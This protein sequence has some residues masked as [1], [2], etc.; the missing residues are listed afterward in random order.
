MTCLFGGTFDPVHLGHTHAAAAVCDALGLS[1]IRLVLSARPSHREPTGASLPQRWEM[2]CLACEE[3]VR[4]VADDREVR[5][6]GPSYTVETLRA[7]RAADADGPLFWVIGS[8]ALVELPSWYRWREVLQLCTL[9]VLRRP[10]FDAVYPPAVARLL[11]GRASADEPSLPRGQIYFVAGEMRQV[12]ASD[13]RRA[14]GSGGPEAARAAHLLNPQVATYITQ[15][16][17]YGAP[18]ER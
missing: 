15:H 5:R 3:D 7:A 4:F 9:I 18:R 12:S 11:E 10:G 17:L 1:E 2:L 6:A 14:L 13:I 8:D 16:G